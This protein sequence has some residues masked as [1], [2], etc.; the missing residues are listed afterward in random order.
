MAFVPTPCPT[1]VQ[2]ACARR[3]EVRHPA[4]HLQSLRPS[5][6]H[7]WRG[8]QPFNGGGVRLQRAALFDGNPIRATFSRPMRTPVKVVSWDRSSPRAGP[9]LG[10]PHTPVETGTLLANHGAVG[11][12]MCLRWRINAP[13]RPRSFRVLP[14]SKKSQRWAG[15][16]SRR[17]PILSCHALQW[18]PESAERVGRPGPAEQ[19]Q[20]WPMRPSAR[21]RRE[22]P[23]CRAPPR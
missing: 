12:Q 13:A 5:A 9:G 18:A 8:R 6:R 2:C 20:P 4:S 17:P 1:A 21:P 16:L 14:L 22:Q 7:P 3:G 15:P 19:V 23:R 10:T 11:A